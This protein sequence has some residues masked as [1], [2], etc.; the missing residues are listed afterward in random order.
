MSLSKKFSQICFVFMLSFFLLSSL[1]H[2]ALFHDYS[3]HGYEGAAQQ[4]ES[5]SRSSSSEF[6]RL[7]IK[8]AGHYLK[9]HAYYLSFLYSVELSGFGGSEAQSQLSLLNVAIS[10]MEKSASIYNRVYQMARYMPYNCDMY[11]KLVFF[12]YWGFQQ[13]KRL[14]QPV[15]RKVSNYLRSGNIDGTYAETSDNGRRKITKLKK[16]KKKLEEE[17]GRAASR[18][19]SSTQLSDLWSLNQEYFEGLLFGQ[20]VSQVF[21]N[22]IGK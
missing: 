20:Y 9:S 15:F 4:Q 21:M 11:W 19:A 18:E 7:I 5:T 3:E 1:S 12:D 16:I 22:L 8:G 14:N 13:T 10:E 2:G 6:R 17:N